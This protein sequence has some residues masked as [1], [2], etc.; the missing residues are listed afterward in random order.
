MNES[1]PSD[2]EQAIEAP[3][4]LVV[5]LKEASRRQIFVPPYIDE[6]VLKAV[7]QHFNQ[8]PKKRFATLYRRLLRPAFAI[9]CVLALWMARLLMPQGDL[10]STIRP[11][12]ARED[13]NHD[14]QVDIL[15]SFALAREL[16]NGKPSP[17]VFDVNGDGVVDER[18]VALIAAHAVQLGKD[19]RS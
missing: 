9:A 5:A 1:N 8:E 2:S 3:A 19:N 18:D 15:D 12:Y 4:K 11:D 17:A 13:L 7:E 14:G 10:K 6:R 16:K